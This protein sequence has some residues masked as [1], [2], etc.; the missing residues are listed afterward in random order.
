MVFKFGHYFL[1]LLDKNFPQQHKLS[2]IFNKN[3]IKSATAAKKRKINHQQ[4]KQKK[5]YVKTDHV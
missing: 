5:F 1:G 4:S 3:T 2:N